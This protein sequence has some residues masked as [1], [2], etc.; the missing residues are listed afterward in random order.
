[1]GVMTFQRTVSHERARLALGRFIASHFNLKPGLGPPARFSIPTEA[2]D[3][4]IVLGD[5]ITQQE[6]LDVKAVRYGDYIAR[7]EATEAKA[8]LADELAAELKNFG[9]VQIG[10]W[11]MINDWLARYDALA[12]PAAEAPTEGAGS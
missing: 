8:A 3:D 11:P 4:D 6:A 1:M 5:Y 2:N 12:A 7:L 9:V 10:A